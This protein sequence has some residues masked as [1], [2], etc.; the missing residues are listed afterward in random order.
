MTIAVQTAQNGDPSSDTALA[1]IRDTV[2][3]I[4]QASPRAMSSRRNGTRGS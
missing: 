1:R 4:S 2:A 3:G